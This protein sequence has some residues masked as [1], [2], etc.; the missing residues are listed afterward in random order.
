MTSHPDAL[1]VNSLVFAGEQ[2]AWWVGCHPTQKH[3]KIVAAVLIWQPSVTCR[4]H[5][6]DH[7]LQNCCE[8]KVQI[9][10]II[11]VVWEWPIFELLVLILL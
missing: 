9:L 7:D 2:G 4:G 10:F 3:P 5:S 6:H 11:L 1:T 8:R